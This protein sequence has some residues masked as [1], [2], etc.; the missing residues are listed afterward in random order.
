VAT[1]VSV[2]AFSAIFSQSKN[3]LMPVRQ[4]ALHGLIK[5]LS[6]PWL[7]ITKVISLIRGRNKCPASAADFIAW[8]VDRRRVVLRLLVSI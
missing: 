3:L 5:F 1:K 7:S 8:L 6:L 4:F 2:D